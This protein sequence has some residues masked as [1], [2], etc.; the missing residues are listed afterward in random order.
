MVSCLLHATKEGNKAVRVKTE[1]PN[2]PSLKI[3][4]KIVISQLHLSHHP[5]DLLTDDR[6]ENSTTATIDAISAKTHRSTDLSKTPWEARPQMT[7][8]PTSLKADPPP[9]DISVLALIV[10]AH[11]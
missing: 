2:D 6:N 1:P 9:P 4:A 8:P 3:G 10:L 11:A 5:L 7:L